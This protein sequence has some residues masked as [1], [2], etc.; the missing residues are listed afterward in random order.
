MDE[1]DA[2]LRERLRGSGRPGAL[3]HIFR[4]EDARRIRDFLRK[5]GAITPGPAPAPGSAHPWHP[6]GIRGA[7][8]G[9]GGH[10]GAPR[11]LPGPRPAAAAAGRVR[12]ERLEPPPAAGGRRAGPRRGSPPGRVALN[13]SPRG[14]AEPLGKLRHGK[15]RCAAQVRSLSGTI[16]VEQRFLSPESSVRLRDLGTDPAATPRPLRAQVGALGGN[17]EGARVG[18][19]GAEPPLCALA[20]GR[21]DLRRRAGGPGG[22]AGLQLRPRRDGRTP[23]ASSTATATA[24]T[25]RGAGT[26]RLLLGALLRELPGVLG[27]GRIKCSER[28]GAA[29]S[30]S[31]QLGVSLC[32]SEVEGGLPSPP[33]H[34]IGVRGHF[35]PSSL[36][37]IMV[38]GH[39]PP[40]HG[41]QGCSGVPGWGEVASPGGGSVARFGPGAIRGMSFARAQPRQPHTQLGTAGWRC[42]EVGGAMVLLRPVRCKKTTERGN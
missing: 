35:P 22:P 18:G 3:W 40:S 12:G 14:C 41:G 10:G 30:T 6:T 23:G 28:A 7:G 15:P 29:G 42:P 17:L 34:P 21:D 24:G 39:F 8:A 37:P 25:P 33:L 2:A 16:S 27:A 1:L 19:S 38:R 5:V 13:P 31:T 9:G 36:H 26:G 11:P 4:A 20:D 32:H